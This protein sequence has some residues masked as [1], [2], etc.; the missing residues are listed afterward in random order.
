MYVACTCID[1]SVLEF[2]LVKFVAGRH[3]ILKFRPSYS[4]L[5]A[6]NCSGVRSGLMLDCMAAARRN[7]IRSFTSYSIIYASRNFGEY[8]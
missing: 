3:S 8:Y 4:N 2:V 7:I 1:Q 5:L 6:K